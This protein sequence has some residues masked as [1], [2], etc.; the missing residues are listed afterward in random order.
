M[1]ASTPKKEWDASHRLKYEP[2]SLASHEEELMCQSLFKIR[3]VAAG[4]IEPEANGPRRA[5]C[6]LWWPPPAARTPAHSDP[7]ATFHCFCKSIVSVY[8]ACA[9][10]V[11]GE[12]VSHPN[13]GPW[14]P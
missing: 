12:S 9:Y 3:N 8:L 13:N 11:S 5:G 7:Q 10:R 1:H 6:H 2:F 14:E 4:S